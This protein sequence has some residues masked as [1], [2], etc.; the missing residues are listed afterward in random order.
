M[1]LILDNLDGSNGFRLDGTEKGGSVG[2][3]VNSVGDVNGDGFDDVAVGARRGNPGGEG[4][5]GS[6]YIV[7]G[8]ASGFDAAMDLSS[9]DGSNGFHVDGTTTYDRSTVSIDDTG[10][11]NGDGV[12][13]MLI[14]VLGFD[15]QG[16][17][18]GFNYIVFGKTS[19][20]DAEMD[21][22]SLDGSDGFRV[23]GESDSG[24]NVLIESAGDINGDGFA[25][26]VVGSQRADLNGLYSQSNFVVLGTASGFD[27]ILDLSSLNGQN[28][29]I[30]NGAAVGDQFHYAIRSAGDF[31][32]DGFA[33][34][35]VGAPGADP[36]GSD[37][38]SSYVVF[39]RASGF[40]AA[41]DLSSLDGSNGFRLDG[42]AEG[43]QSGSVVSSA[44]DI[45]GDGFDDVIV[46]APGANYIPYGYYALG[47]RYVVFGKGSGFDAAFDLSDLDG[48]DG[49]RLDGASSAHSSASSAG[50]ING[51]GF[52]DVLVETAV[53]SRYGDWE[54]A[55]VVFGKASGFNAAESISRDGNNGF[56]LKAGDP[57]VFS[58]TNPTMTFSVAGDVNG[59]GFDDLIVG[60]GN[61]ADS[62]D[63]G[64]SYVVFGKASGFPAT[65]DLFSL[66]S[67]IGLRLDGTQEGDSAGFSVSNA[68]VNGDGIDDVMIG[69]P[70]ADPSGDGSGSSYVV[71]G[72]SD[73]G[74]EV[75][76]GTPGDDEFIGTAAAEHFAAGGGNDTI[77]GGGGADVLNGESGDDVIRVPD[78]DFLSVDGGTGNDTLELAGSGIDM[79]L[80]DFRIAVSDIETIDLTGNGDNALT[81][82]A[83]DVLSLSD[84]TN[85]LVIKGNAGDRVARPDGGWAD[86][87]VQGNFHAFTKQGAVLLIDAAVAT[88]PPD[89]G[90]IS[91][92][93]LN[94][95]NGFRLDGAAKY[96]MSGKSVSNVGDVNGDG[97]DDV[98]I[99]TARYNGNSSPSYV[100][101]GK[102]S[103]FDAAMSLSGSS[104]DGN[105]GFRLVG[106]AAASFSDENPVSNAGDVNGDGFGDLIIGA[107]G[108]DPHGDG[109]GSSYVVFGKA[110]GF[111]AALDL[112]GLN[113]NNGFRLDG[114][115]GDV[116]GRSVSN[117]GDVNGDGFDDVIV[118]APYV[119]PDGII[120]A[121][122]S[123]V[124]FGQTSGFAATLNLSGLDG[125]NGF[126]LDGAVS[127]DNSGYSVSGAGDVNGDGFDDVIVSARAAAP[128]GNP[129]AGSGYIV[130]GKASGFD[131]AMDLASLDGGNGFRLDGE[132]AFDNLG[133]SVDSAGDVNGDGFDDVIISTSLADPNG[134]FSSGSSYVVFGRASGFDA[135]M[136]LSSLDGSNGF[137]IDGV[138]GEG[139]GKSVSSAGDVNGDGFDDVIIGSGSGIFDSPD[140]SYLIFGKAS[141][142]AA[143]MNLSNIDGSN[144]VRLDGIVA[145]SEFL[146]TS[147]S[148][149]GDIN[150]DG[151]DD[152]I[153]GVPDA[154]PN[155]DFSGS[156]YVIFGRSD[157]GGGQLP[158]IPGTPGDDVLRGT[159]AAEIF[160]AG[161][162]ND[163][164]IGRGGADVFHGG[165]GVD[166]IKVPDLNFESIDGGT[167][168]DILHLDGKD[169]N[170]DLTAFG[171]KIHGIETICL[172]GRG[173]N[174]L[175]LTADSM[176]DLSDT[177]NILKLHGNAGDR[178]TVQDNGWIDG[179]VKGFYHTYTNDD[180]VLLVGANLAIDFV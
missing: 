146:G 53:F 107:P 27:G 149:A 29:F 14:H 68:D 25:D 158:I 12:E 156:S 67:S 57:S 16:D 161:D 88:D 50:D 153:V 135:V 143:A 164:L 56:L 61:P 140:S 155:G 150:N 154:D 42:T 128:N 112:S 99:G 160:E 120:S 136:S 148:G 52:D 96:D 38:G 55:Y 83:Q 85:M 101:F 170:L 94:G 4:F 175:T 45:N 74:V 100:V 93:G 89:P 78:L 166:Q 165:A 131:A 62:S 81:L 145:G 31:N 163:L 26:V 11:I 151:F 169:L 30:L 98:I 70:G 159:S 92:F 19:G 114:A 86:G 23:Q 75:I 59:D 130:F 168:N 105:N 63:P 108:A 3:S 60:V 17:R 84:T 47:A 137:R 104:L 10:D 119:D 111:S 33:D 5:T 110:S 178:V 54:V 179:G 79:N 127:G 18:A 6:N 102:A 142:F 115:K 24:A 36:H 71:F 157:F 106:P 43:D 66:D 28:G 174:M 90:A 20:F 58:Y 76:Q 80:A 121:G 69:A 1:A 177:S 9:L 180:A 171:D 7:F 95:D 147:V 82:T 65:L 72:S 176:L 144:G 122:A 124:I 167:G 2:S 139:S 152:L 13:D 103:G 126:R 34:V 97:F 40:D 138:A 109:S 132:A 162:G 35:I 87:G 22:S 49:F 39:G 15:L 32:G 172:Y 48:S 123:Y 133:E 64:S 41:L 134:V 117:A 91:L 44:G 173:D 51:D 125:S 141:G 118:S 113:G 46:D 73:F 8:K 77:T 21:L 116:S 129:R 37:S